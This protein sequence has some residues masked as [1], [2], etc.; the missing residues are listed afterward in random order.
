VIP[1]RIEAVMAETP[2]HNTDT[3]YVRRVAI[4]NSLFEAAVRGNDPIRAAD[5]AVA[6]LE[7]AGYVIGRP[8]KLT[9]D[10]WCNPRVEVVA[11]DAL[12]CDQ[13]ADR[14][15]V[16]QKSAMEIGFRL[17]LAAKVRR[18]QDDLDD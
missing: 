17:G 9:A 13:N 11:G 5:L 14:S 16:S 10:C 1:T 7:A 2:C 18:C 8:H 4:V 12:V 3:S 6:N 15:R